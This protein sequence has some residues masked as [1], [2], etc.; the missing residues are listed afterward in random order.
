[1][2][3]QDGVAIPVV[4]SLLDLQHASPH[5]FMPKSVMLKTVTCA[6]IVLVDPLANTKV[7]IVAYS[8]VV[9]NYSSHRTAGG[10]ATNPT[11]IACTSL[12]TISIQTHFIHY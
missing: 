12:G 8:L 3:L 6:K 11:S 1:M 9:F 10:P 2:M 7:P 5:V 4:S